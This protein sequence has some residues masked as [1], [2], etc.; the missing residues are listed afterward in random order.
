VH[1]RAAIRQSIVCFIPITNAASSGNDWLN[2]K[3]IEALREGDFHL[4]TVSDGSPFCSFTGKFHRER[5]EYMKKILVLSDSHGNI[6]NMVYAVK[7]SAPDMICHLGDCWND[8][9]KLRKIFPKI[10]MERV[11]GNCDYQ[12]EPQEKIL[13]IE[14]KKILIC[15]GHQYAVKSSL[16]SLELAAREK[17]VDLALFG[18][19]HRVFYDIHHGVMLFNPG[20][21]GAPGYQIP[22]SYG[23]LL[24]AA[25][26][27]QIHMETRYIEPAN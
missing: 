18:H 19:T 3:Q 17:G 27:E 11:P 2:G 4:T 16:L 12:N 20:S 25:D 21:I 24:I 10:P 22:P 5:G 8:A 23:E 15:H 7:K 26:D 13:L 6:N 14:G 9:S 1:R